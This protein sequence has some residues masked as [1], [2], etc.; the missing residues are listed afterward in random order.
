MLSSLK[1]ILKNQL[2]RPSNRDGFTLIELLVAIIL[3]A[4]IITPVLGFMI[5]FLQTDRKEQAKTTTEQ[6][7]QAALDY[8]AQDIQQA[9]Y[10]YDQNGLQ[11]SGEDGIRDE[12]ET[13]ICE[14][15][16]C[17][18]ILVFWKRRFL[19]QDETINGQS[20]GSFTNSNDVFVYALV[21]YALV[22]NPENDDTWSPTARIVRYELRDGLDIDGDQVDEVPA[23]PSGFEP[24][25]L[26][27]K[28]TLETKMNLWNT[29]GGQKNGATLI[30][31]IDEPK[32]EDEAPLIQC[33]QQR[34]EQRIPAQEADDPSVGF[35]TCIS[36]LPSESSIPTARVY[37]RG[38]ALA[39]VPSLK[40]A[41]KDKDDY[42][43][44]STFFPTS[45][46]QVQGNS[47]LFTQ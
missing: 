43:Q 47:F 38:N 21:A 44:Y 14:E 15:D 24:F 39:R 45:S 6:D 29:P 32:S 23:S 3:A 30:D 16:D 5:N 19:S 34:G 37:M 10:I 26:S 7:I 8:I 1:F 28:G 46:I 31:F 20:V 42:K 4:L 2:K 33:Q 12:L 9:V 18:P 11:S 13:S 22:D 27:E 41:V 36:T 17:T 35:V 40:D 25:D